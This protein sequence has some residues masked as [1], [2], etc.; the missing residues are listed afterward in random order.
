MSPADRPTLR[1][2]LAFVLAILVAH[3]F[4]ELAHTGAGRVACGAWGARDFNVWSLAE[5]CESRL[6][7][8]AGPVFSWAV[9]WIGVWFV[10]AG[11]EEGRWTGLALIFAPKP[12]GR[13][14]PALVGGGDEGVLARALV[15]GPGIAARGVVIVAAALF[16]LHPLLFAWHALP[17]RR[18]LGWFLMLFASGILVTGPLLFVVGNGLLA[19]GVLAGPGLL[20]A[21]ILVEV[22]TLMSCAGLALTWRDLRN[23]PR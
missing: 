10:R 9:M 17:E 14:L 16:V 21:P 2:L 12:L 8:L 22:V 1:W 18:R 20:G 23:A 15:G 6:A 7:T 11:T 4:H 5:G 19:R 3:E 13:L